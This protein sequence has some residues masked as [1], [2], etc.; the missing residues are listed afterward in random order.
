LHFTRG[1]GPINSFAIY[2]ELIPHP[3]YHR[4]NGL[5][6]CQDEH[7]T[8]LRQILKR[9]YGVSVE[10][11][12]QLISF[13]HASN[14]VVARLV[15]TLDNTKETAQFDWLV[16]A[17]GVNSTVRGKL[18]LELESYGTSENDYIVGDV[19]AKIAHHSTRWKVW[20]GN[21]Q[22]TYPPPYTKDGKPY[23]QFTCGGHSINV[24][25]WSRRAETSS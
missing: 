10:L 8:I 25:R 13:E 23:F 16:G 4:I 20:G 11:G 6:I 17:D 1:F 22:R 3:A 21:V 5:T 18:G 15:N 14:S 24:A 9:E 12:T 7:E 2:E 19:E